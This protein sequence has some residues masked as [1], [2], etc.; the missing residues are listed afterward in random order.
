M[1]KEVLIPGPDHP[2]TI[3]P[4]TRRVIVRVGEWVI[5]ES[6]AALTLREAGYPP[7]QY[8]PLVD[9][10][11]ARLVPSATETYCPYKGDAS[12]Y[13]ISLPE[14]QIA[15]AIW[16]YVSPYDAVSDIA[17]HVAFYDARDGISIEM[18]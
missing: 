15:D 17:D 13:S 12:Y 16:A 8:L 14:R 10:D 18:I 3:E 7:V 4:T 1:S 9:V 2:I 11:L 6:N 5:A